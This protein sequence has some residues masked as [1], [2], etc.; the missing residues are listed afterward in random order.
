[1]QGADPRFQPGSQDR[2]HLIIMPEATLFPQGDQ[3][4]VVP[5]IPQDHSTAAPAGHRLHTAAAVLPE[6]PEVIHPAALPVAIPA[7]ALHQAHL[8]A[9]QAAVPPLAD[10][11]RVAEDKLYFF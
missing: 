7:V 2:H 3:S 11:R 4:K 10:H 9:H 1:M 5:D 8:Q 6:L